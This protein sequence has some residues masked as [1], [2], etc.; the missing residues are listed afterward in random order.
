MGRDRH[1]ASWWLACL[2][3]G[4]VSAAVLA[5][6]AVWPAPSNAGMRPQ[7]PAALPSAALSK[8]RARGEVAIGVRTDFHPFGML[9]A[10]G[11]P[12]GLEIDLARAL[13]DHL[14][15]RLRLVPVTPDDRLAH[16]Q[17]GVV[18]ILIA[19][20]SD[21][22][23]RRLEATAVEPHYYGS[24]VNV[25]LRPERNET[26]WHQLRG[27]TL[28]AVEGA[29]FNAWLAQRHHVSL[30]AEPS[31][32]EALRLLEQDRCAGLLY[33]EGAMQHLRRL[34]DW[35][36]HRMPLDSALVVP[37][38]I[39]L[40]RSEQG[41][42]LEHEVGNALAR[43][44]RDG[45]LIAL[46]KKWGLKPSRLLQ[47]ARARWS[48]TRADG[49]LI[50]TREAGGLWPASCRDAAFVHPQ[51]AQGLLRLAMSLRE[52][53]GIRLAPAGQAYDSA[54][55]LRSL[56]FTGLLAAAMLVG[57]WI[58]ASR[59]LRWAG[60]VRRACMTRVAH[61]TRSVRRRSGVAAATG[62]ARRQARPSAPEPPLSPPMWALLA[63]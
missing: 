31:V 4:F 10:R 58:L 19:A 52:G 51:Q 14:Q 61:F 39:H 17:A 22:P 1:G 15:V 20:V 62:A 7:A 11:R 13:A 24:G 12:R 33:T 26:D 49:T 54:Q 34:P 59:G 36:H 46:E 53:W 6:W 44:H 42:A 48:E 43:W 23:A 50:C 57:A 47:Q 63:S 9:D 40:A 60:P 2:G 27:H 21:T 25:L 18:D 16:L 28:C 38:A 35:R 30:R 45:V 29:P 41:S 56:A 37:W 5:A 3:L 55:Y 8:I 32:A